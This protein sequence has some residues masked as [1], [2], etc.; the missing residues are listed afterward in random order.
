MFIFLG[1]ALIIG[2]IA[3]AL[4]MVIRKNKGKE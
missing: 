2:F 3:L 4:F 1:F